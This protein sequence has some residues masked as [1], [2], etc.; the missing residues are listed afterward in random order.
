MYLWGIT[1]LPRWRE[2]KVPK[3][4]LSLILNASADVFSRPLALCLGPPVVPFYHFC[5]LVEGS[6]TRIDKAENKIEYHYSSLSGGPIV[7]MFP[8][9]PPPAPSCPLPPPAPCPPPPL[10]AP[11]VI[12]PLRPHGRLLP[13]EDR[14]RP[15]HD[16]P[17]GRCGGPALLSR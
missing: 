9:P 10:P 14:R 5:F 17:G 4:S 7:P 2:H 13:E 16:P 11:P 15:P 3:S 8:P 6:P 1:S 12:G